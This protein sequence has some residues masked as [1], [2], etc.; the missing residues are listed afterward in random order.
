MNDV[1]KF[2]GSKFIHA[3]ASVIFLIIVVLT[4]LLFFT[5][6][7]NTAKGS[8]IITGLF[9]G[10][11]IAAF[12]LWLSWYQYE[13]ID[14]FKE[15]KIRKILANRKDQNYYGEL[16][17]KAEKEISLLGITAL[18]FLED[19]ANNNQNAPEKERVLLSALRKQ[20]FKVKILVADKSVLDER[21]KR[22]ADEAEALLKELKSFPNFEFAYYDQHH[23]THSVLI[24][25]DE[26]I[27]GPIFPKVYSRDTPA[28]HLQRDSQLAK[29]YETYFND[30]WEE[31]IKKQKYPS[32]S[33]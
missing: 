33:H 20:N 5:E 29:Y 22:K 13:I 10:V 24:I 31:C 28:I 19:F 3:I 6:I 12:Q 17:S 9:T 25:D 11:I 18:S 2:L 4:Y 8:G 14:E 30:E 7:P 26:F 32:S 23:P 1:K 16:I 15:L 27:V 21:H